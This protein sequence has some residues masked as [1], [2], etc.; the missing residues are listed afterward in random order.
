[1]S[2]LTTGPIVNEI[3]GSVGSRT[4][5]RNAYGPYVK[6]KLVQTNP[7][8]VLQQNRRLF[9]SQAVQAWQNL[10]DSQRKAWSLWS[11]E[12]PSRNSLG[13]RVILSGYNMFISAYL[14]MRSIGESLS[15]PP[16]VKQ[17]LPYF[18]NL[19]VEEDFGDIIL[20]ANIL[21]GSNEYRTMMFIAPQR[22][23]SA[24]F[25]NP[26]WLKYYDFTFAAGLFYM[27]IQQANNGMGFPSFQQD[28]NLYSPVGIK[29]V[30]RNSGLG[31]KMY[32]FRVQSIENGFIH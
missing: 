10:T 25:V 3:R 18:R 21:Q 24:L 9:L 16:F 7:N 17:V 15:N 31:S 1:M 32:L 28:E 22:K 13:R 26:S 19:Q 30:N 6:N 27:N 5:S 2:I 14:N 4:F 12:N 29:F 23:T 8:T 20:S 11:K